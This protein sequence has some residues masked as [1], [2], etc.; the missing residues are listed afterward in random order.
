MNILA[1][2]TSALTATAAILSD[3]TLL[4]EISTTTKLT[5]SQTIMPMIDEL[6]K[7]VSLDIS[8]IDLFACS[9]G[10]G[11]F[12]G[13]RIGIGTIKGLAYGLGKPV[14]GVSTLEALAHNISYT[15]F[16]IA[17]I[18]DARRGQVYNALYHYN[19]GRLD[20][21]CEPRALSLEELCGELAEKTIFVGDGVKVHR[22]KIT[23]LLGEKALFAPPQHQ[24]QRAGSVAYAALGK[25]PIDAAE[26][27]AV[28][29]RKPQAEREREERIENI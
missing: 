2:D 22:E 9:Q 7:K 10:P 11:S 29:L 13:L 17:P 5:H 23:E 6:L 18:M 19:R 21:F 16:T 1:I 20:C 3:D 4:G 26:L 28:Y 27:T 25:M 15:D 14:V 8:D 12:T 24:L